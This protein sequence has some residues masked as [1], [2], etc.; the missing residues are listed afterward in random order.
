MLIAGKQRFYFLPNLFSVLRSLQSVWYTKCLMNLPTVPA[1]QV[2]SLVVG[3]LVNPWYLNAKCVHQF[4]DNL[5]K[6]HVFSQVCWSRCT[7]LTIST[8]VSHEY[9]F[10]WRSWHYFKRVLDR[11]FLAHETKNRRT[12]SYHCAQALK[13]TALFSRRKATHFRRADASFFTIRRV[14][15]DKLGRGWCRLFSSRSIFFLPNP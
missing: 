15:H 2:V 8:V 10:N 9:F 13:Q 11:T 4:E 1:V 7:L 12:S 3:C 14:H 5:L 6:L